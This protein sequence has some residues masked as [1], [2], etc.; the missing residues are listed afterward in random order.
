[1]GKMAFPTDPTAWVSQ[2]FG[3]NAQSYPGMKGHN[4]ID[5]SRSKVGLPIYAAADG[6]VTVA[7]EKLK[8]YGRHVFIHHDEHGGFITIY[9][10]LQSMSVKKGDKVQAGQQI[11][12]MG[13]DPTDADPYD[14]YSTGPHL[15]FELRPDEESRSNGFY[16]AVDPFPW[17]MKRYYGGPKYRVK[18]V[19]K[20]GLMVRPQPDTK[21]T[22]SP[23]RDALPYGKEIDII[24]ILVDT[25]AKREWA[26]LYTPWEG[27]AAFKLGD[28]EYMRVIKVYERAPVEVVST[29]PADEH[30][31]DLVTAE[32]IASTFIP[33]GDYV[34]IEQ[35]AQHEDVTKDAVKQWIEAGQLKA[36]KIGDLGYIINKKDYSEFR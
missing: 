14:G 19:S 33:A 23:K 10:H 9:G 15:H 16:G 29:T 28:D 27:Y 11:G 13:G 4:G 30:I 12:T 36:L 22:F 1:M 31:D 21:A 7:V 26:R 24:D 3:V 34:T 25:S 18:V 35:I 32:S 6:V 17:L 8:S 2:V 20:Y 5:L